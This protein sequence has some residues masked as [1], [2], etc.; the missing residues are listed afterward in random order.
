MTHV[1]HKNV[2]RQQQAL[3]QRQP[4]R[5][6]WVD[7]N[8]L[9]ATVQLNEGAT[10]ALVRRDHRRVSR[11]ADVVG[12]PPR[13]RHVRSRRILDLDNLGSVIGEDGAR[14]RCGHHCGEL[15]DAHAL[16]KTLAF[17]EQRFGAGTLAQVRA[18]PVDSPLSTRTALVLI[19]PHTGLSHERVRVQP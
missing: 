8:A 3:H 6:A 10:P 7:G 9:L 18:E 5:L 4:F 16:Q 17:G 13:A 19:L 1:C 15:N 12:T 14:R 11:H 2:S